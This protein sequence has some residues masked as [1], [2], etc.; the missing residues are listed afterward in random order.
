MTHNRSKL[1]RNIPKEW[2]SS[3]AAG[4]MWF[5]RF[6]R[7]HPKLSLRLPEATSLARASAFNRKNVEL[8]FKN[9]D[10]AIENMPYKPHRI[11]NVDET[12]ATTVHKP[13]KVVSRTG[14]KQV[15]QIKSTEQGELISVAL[16]VNAAGMRAP[17]YVIFPRVRYQRYFLNG[18][19]GSWGNATKSGFMNSECFYDF[20]QKFQ[21]FVKSTPEDPIILVLDNHVSHRS[22]ETLKFCREN[23]IRLL[24]FPPHTSHRLQPLDVSVFGPFQNSKDTLLA[25]W[26]KSNPGRTMLIHDMAPIICRALENAATERN[27]KAG[28]R[29]TGI[30]PLDRQIVQEIDF[31]PAETTD[32]PYE[33][34]VETPESDYFA[35]EMDYFADENNI[36]PAGVEIE[37]P[38]NIS[39][40]SISC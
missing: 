33:G 6:I 20:I 27:V 25:D 31:M 34:R 23:G 14:R 9:L 21:A 16:A 32:R 10:A 12:K 13:K 28:F 5:K 37:L 19:P 26:C 7:D 18:L 2:R 35:P 22:Y 3:K 1:N 40:Q 38:L 24:S 11:W 8:F 29:A 36:P 39:Q 4:R 30:Y 17:P 15:G